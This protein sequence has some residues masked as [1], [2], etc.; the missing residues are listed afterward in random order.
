MINILELRPNPH[1]KSDGIDKYCNALRLL[2]QNDDNVNILPIENYPMKNT[3]VLKEFYVGSRLKEEIQRKDIDIIHIN[4]FASFSVLQCFWL[5]LKA[6]K[7]IVYTAHWHPFNYLNHPFR[8]KVFFYFFLRPLVKLGSN[9]IIAINSEDYSFFSRIRENVKRI[10]HWVEITQLQPKIEKD[11]FMILFVG[12]LNDTNKGIEHLLHLPKGEYHIHCVGPGEIELREDFIRHVDVSSEELQKLYSKASLLV[13]PSRYEAFSYVA[14]EALSAGTP[15]L[16]S[17]RV[18][19]A[20]Y[21]EGVQGVDV[22]KYQDYSEFCDRV[23]RSIGA[24]VDVEVINSI[25]SIDKIKEQYK[26]LFL[27]IANN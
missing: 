7:K 27:E 13:V 21:L 22:F 1:S 16:L 17:N 23:K 25:F 9:A 18:R 4:G 8:A 10:P 14:L 15:V 12:R 3:G 6:K 19:I 2:F 26:S 11:P 24:K 5:A 20:D